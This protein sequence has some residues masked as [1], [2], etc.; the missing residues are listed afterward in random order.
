MELYVAAQGNITLIVGDS[1]EVSFTQTPPHTF[2]VNS[3]VLS[4]ASPVWRA[5]FEPGRWKEAFTKTVLLPEDDGEALLIL[6][7][8]CHGRFEDIPEV[9]SAATLHEIAILCDKYDCITLTRPW[10]KKWLIGWTQQLDITARYKAND[11]CI[12]W[13]FGL[14]Q[15]FADIEWRLCNDSQMNDDDELWHPVHGLFDTA[16]IDERN[17]RKFCSRDST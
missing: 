2:H 11:L 6:L 3:Q 8:I 7:Q 9:L 1:T 15:A 5:M 10:L 4:Q 12:A 16:Y 17:L 13:Q 14:S